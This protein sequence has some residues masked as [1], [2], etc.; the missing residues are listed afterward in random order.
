MIRLK[1]RVT[2]TLMRP[3]Y[4]QA[5]RIDMLSLLCHTNPGRIYPSEVVQWRQDV[6][7]FHIIRTS[8][9]IPQPDIAQ[10]VLP[11]CVYARQV[12]TA[13]DQAEIYQFGS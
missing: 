11:I 12:A 6:G 8:N 3:T 2:T 13:P 10:T 4:L 1:E 7:H 5:S 9:D